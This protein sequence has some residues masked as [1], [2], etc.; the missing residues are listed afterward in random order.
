M[1]ERN[2]TW[3]STPLDRD[4]RWSALGTRGGTLWF[5]GLSGAGKSTIA[6]ELERALVLASIWAYRLDGDN[7]RTGLNGDLGFS[8][9]DR[10]ENLR[11][12][13]EVS[14]LFADAGAI[15]ITSTISPLRRHRD[16]A[17]RLYLDRGL[18]FAEVFISTPIDVCRRRDPKKL[19]EKADRG[20]IADFTGV[21][22]PY[23]PP[24]HPE[25]TI[26]AHECTVD[27]AARSCLDFLTSER[28]VRVCG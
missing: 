26:A 27:Q 16:D 4:R 25:L 19:Y 7:V 20:L 23:E 17:R 6:I 24:V 13:S 22:A 8:P 11:R 3:H 12:I 5:T 28:W 1:A 14:L 10:S 2:V 18:P 15:C 9:E 21:S